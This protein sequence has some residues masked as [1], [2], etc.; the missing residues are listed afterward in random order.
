MKDGTLQRNNTGFPCGTGSPNY[1]EKLTVIAL[2]K[3]IFKKLQAM[4]FCVPKTSSQ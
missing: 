1:M 2:I 4:R 3:Y